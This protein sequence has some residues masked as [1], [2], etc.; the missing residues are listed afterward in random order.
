[1]KN[2]VLSLLILIF[3]FTQSFCQKYTK[4]TLHTIIT[5]EQVD[6]ELDSINKSPSNKI[7]TETFFDEKRI[8]AVTKDFGFAETTIRVVNHKDSAYYYVFQNTTDPPT[9]EKNLKSETINNLVNSEN[10]GNQKTDSIVNADS[11]FNLMCYKVFFNSKTGS[12]WMILTPDIKMFNMIELENIEI[13]D[14]NFLLAFEFYDKE[15]S[16]NIKYTTTKFLP[17]IK[18]TSVFDL[19]LQDYYSMENI[20]ETDEDTDLI[21]KYS[22]YNAK[23]STLLKDLYK[24]GLIE[25]YPYEDYAKNNYDIELVDIINLMAIKVSNL[26]TFNRDRLKK[27]FEKYNLLHGTIDT[28]FRMEVFSP[29][30]KFRELLKAVRIAAI[31]DF[32]LHPDNK[33]MFLNNAILHGYLQYNDSLE[34]KFIKNKIE[35]ADVLNEFNNLI[36]LDIVDTLDKTALV[37]SIAD[38]YKKVLKDDF[39]HVSVNHDDTLV[40][41][42]DRQWVHTISVIDALRNQPSG[43]SDYELSDDIPH[44]FHPSIRLYQNLLSF[45]NQIAVD[46]QMEYEFNISTFWKLSDVNWIIFDS[47]QLNYPFLQASKNRI[48]FIKNLNKVTSEYIFFV[49]TPDYKLN[50]KFAKKMN[51]YRNTII[52]VFQKSPISTDKKYQLI[53]FLS[54]YRSELSVNE[55]HQEKLQKYLLNS[56]IKY[57]SDLIENSFFANLNI[58]KYKKTLLKCGIENI[59]PKKKYSLPEFYPNLNSF[60]MNDDLGI[61]DIRYDSKNYKLVFKWKK[62]KYNLDDSSKTLLDFIVENNI[63]SKH[64]KQLLRYEDYFIFMRPELF[65]EFKKILEE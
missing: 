58:I 27:V 21:Q 16:M 52:N 63:T 28:V 29:H 48:Y 10:F 60:M 50:K 9:F 56:Y 39:P 7:E 40:Y 5:Y 26:N 4:G 31:K 12:G 41:I 35:Y 19:S 3:C 44:P 32:L 2:L 57:S 61:S 46:N 22:L 15:L 20:F 38:F 54:K 49:N 30:E 45:V 42:S 64:G 47:L 14:T 53:N 36:P 51:F 25:N 34:N 23:N 33:R 13:I 43:L 1:M 62:K 17:E 65:E 55:E 6:N 37:R 59:D 11:L 8:S 18:D 24:E